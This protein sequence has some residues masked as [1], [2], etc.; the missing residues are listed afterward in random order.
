M[1]LR[2]SAVFPAIL[3]ALA[4]SSAALPAGCSGEAPATSSSTGTGGA[5][6]ASSSSGAT[7]SSGSGG[8]AP[9]PHTFMVSGTVTDG[10]NPVEGAF[11]LQGGAAMPAM[12]TGPDGAY[13]I[14]LTQDI[15]GIPTV[16]ATKLGYRT[17][18]VEFIALPEGPVDLDLRIVSPPDNTSYVYGD[19]G[20]G[21]VEHDNST[22]Y[23]GH[24]H[25]SFVAQFQTS[26]HA[27]ATRDPLVQDLYAG[28]TEAFTTQAACVAAGGLWKVGLTPG[29]PQTPVSK[30]YQGGGVLPDLNPGCG[31]AGKPACDDPA[32]PVAQKPTAFGRCADCHAP[33]IDGK[34]GGRNLHDA[35]GIA[36]EHGNHCDPC[37][38]VR[39]VDLQKPPGVAGALVMQRPSDKISDDPTAKI[40]QVMFGPLLDVPN[41]FMGGSY[42]PKFSTSELC[43]GCHEQ[44]QEAMLPG[45]ALDPARWPN[46]LPTH[47][48]FTEWSEGAFNTPGTQC[49][50]CH[51]PADDTGLLNT[52]DVT[53]D[54]SVAGI[55]F[56]FI[57]P[58]S[59]IRKHIFRSPLEGSPRFI[60]QA[61]GLSFAT[62]SDGVTLT[63]D[64]HVQ[65]NLAGHAIPTGEP[66]RA[67]VLLVRAD[68]CGSPMD[69]SQG[70]TVN[71]TGGALAQG[72][73]GNGVT[74]VG[75]S[76]TWAQG[77]Q[78]A[79][80][81]DVIRV[82]RSTG[83]YDDYEGIGFFAD[84]LLSPM[85]K[86]LEIQT[87]VGEATVTNVAAGVLTLSGSLPL[88]AGDVVYLGDALTGD[89]ADGD[90]SRSLAGKPGY[91]F[92]R[93][94]VD[95]SG[96]R[97]VP[98]Y[99]A[100]DM[101]SDNR[102]A[103]QATAATTHG[104]S[105]PVGCAMGSVTATLVYR[106]V[107][108][109]LA[110]E[111]GWAAKDYVIAQTTMSVALP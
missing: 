15:P 8:E 26:A 27:K 90:T 47:S 89:V 50:F 45:S 21:T 108:S 74:A 84:P 65:N 67:L 23:C 6:S 13:S 3:A 59:Q 34:A 109:V 44:K 79:K 58:P 88:Q 57:R 97:H 110:K 101:V 37:H 40:A 39:D 42:Q 35:E 83:L 28:V 33:G 49:Q 103:P 56:G 55:T 1:I 98:H 4:L 76:L 24:C 85:E 75:P 38:H 62:S 30:C 43:A 32:I 78:R 73:I 80:V 11:V 18:G 25:T 86:G 77:A 10:T 7:S 14:T 72:V 70:M 69:P 81:G 106:P 46:G 51:M 66:M 9:L 104:F 16:V 94:L 29:S 87:P 20:I 71:D 99:R 41:G 52:L 64:V 17:R 53:K 92:A 22:K 12:T 60:N 63:V 5:S 102:V 54:P 91:T 61:V 111:R 2:R 100:V 95:P 36:F 82:V 107:P 31:G 93:V 105:I 48:T 19:P 68:A 96:A